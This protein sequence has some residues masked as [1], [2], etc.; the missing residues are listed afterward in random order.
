MVQL[1]S[2]YPD[3]DGLQRNLNFHHYGVFADQLH[4]NVVA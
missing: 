3:A 1:W 4:L 2:K